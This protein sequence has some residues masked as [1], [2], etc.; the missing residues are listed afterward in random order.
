MA[1]NLSVVEPPAPLSHNPRGIVSPFAQMARTHGMS[2]MCD[3]MVAV[4]LAGSIF[5][6]IDPAAARW[7]VA[8]YL[9]LTIAPFAVVTPLIG[10]AVDRIRGGRRL[11][12]V[13]TVLGRAVLAYLMSEHIDGLLLFPEAFCFLVLQKGYSVA[14]SA[15][16]PG[17]VRTESELV[18]ANSKLALMGAVSSMVGAGI[19]GLAMLVGH[20]WPPRVACVGFV[21][22]AILAIGLKSITVAEEPMAAGERADLRRSGILYGAVAIAVLRA[23]VGFVTFLLAFAFRG[24]AE[25]VA[26]EGVG[27]AG[28][29]A[30]GLARG[31]NVFGTPGAPAW[32]FGA[33]LA[34]A[35]LGAL[36][37]AVAAPRLRRRLT[38]E[39]I[40]GGALFLVMTAAAF[41]VWVSGVQGA[42]SMAVAVA[43]C[44]LA[45]K[46]A[47]DSL[48]QRD[49]PNANHG[50]SFARFEG[51]F[52]LSWAVGAFVPT[53]LSLRPVMGYVSV[54]VAMWLVMGVYGG[55]FDR[56][57][58]VQTPEHSDRPDGQLG[59][60]H[61]GQEGDGSA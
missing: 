43:G 37:G 17:L 45:A 23:T 11:M 47:F 4:A 58:R 15:V 25:G 42:V 60:W 33:V 51:R 48:V 44:A 7:R 12:I 18:G 34:G 24:G 56:I 10:P 27:R 38:E 59:F 2:S 39:R 3:A 9:V 16:V 40:I 49:A 46:L 6:S 1:P 36:V 52:Q 61:R 20:E 14:K 5:F 30:V 21:V 55:V 50:R 54:L 35:G 31:E 22:T 57:L 26:L 53:V 19:G 8:L 13:L 28:G 32:H 41:A 29:A